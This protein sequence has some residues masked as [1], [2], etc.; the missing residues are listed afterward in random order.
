M[1]TLVQKDTP[2]TTPAKPEREPQWMLPAVNIYESP[3]GY[4]LEAEMPGVNK[5][6]LEVT[7]DNNELT[8]VGHRETV[9]LQPEVIHRESKPAEFRRTFEVDPS[10]DTGAITAQMDQ[11]LLTLRLP[12]AQRLQPRKIAVG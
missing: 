9:P 6:G 2:T 12:K 11:G 5:K 1:K 4:L 8:I 10:I 7:L 3:E